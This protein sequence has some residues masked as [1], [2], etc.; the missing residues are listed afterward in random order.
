MIEPMFKTNKL[1]N[2]NGCYIQKVRDATVASPVSKENDR[3]GKE[4]RSRER[5]RDHIRMKIVYVY[6]IWKRILCP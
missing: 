2:L 5:C 4:R 1:T 3:L 6:E